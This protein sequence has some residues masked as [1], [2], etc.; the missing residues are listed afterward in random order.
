MSVESFY[1]E[2]AQAESV[3]ELEPGDRFEIFAQAAPTKQDLLGAPQAD[4]S[5]YGQLRG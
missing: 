2:L 5:T 1:A 3:P 4:I